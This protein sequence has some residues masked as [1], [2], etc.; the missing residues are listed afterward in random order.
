MKKLQVKLVAAKD[1]G[2]PNVNILETG[3]EKAQSKLISS[4]KAL[5]DYKKASNSE[6]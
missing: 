1:S 2:D 5:D 4:Q 3:L 6:D